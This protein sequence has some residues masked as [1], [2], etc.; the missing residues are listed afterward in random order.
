MEENIQSIK[1]SIG[2]R[3]AVAFGWEKVRERILFFAAVTFI[4]YSLANIIMS[5]NLIAGAMEGALVS[6]IRLV[7]W[8]IY[9]FIY[10]FLMA[11]LITILLKTVKGESSSLRDFLN[12]QKYV[13]PILAGYFLYFLIIAIGSLFLIIP[14]IFLAMRLSFVLLLIIDKSMGP[15]TALKESY[16]LTKGYGW[17]LFLLAFIV[18]PLLFIVGVLAF[19][20]GSFI[21]P[22]IFLLAWTFFYDRIIT[23]KLELTH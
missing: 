15:I 13:F 19:L 2:V 11:G 4:S 18:G 3:E 22:P 12:K 21:V 20:V 1:K 16:R 10:F 14:G 6:L 23:L 5:L 8:L 9:V 17:K 7:G